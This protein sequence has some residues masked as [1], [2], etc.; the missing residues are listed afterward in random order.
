MGAGEG[1]EAAEKVEGGTVGAVGG[2]CS[3]SFQR[4]SASIVCLLDTQCCSLLGTRWLLVVEGGPEEVEE[5]DV[6]GAVEGVGMAEG[7]GAGAAVG[8]AIP[9]V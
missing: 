6:E 3:R 2:N 9:A 7:V 5:A 8:A 1:R 4:T